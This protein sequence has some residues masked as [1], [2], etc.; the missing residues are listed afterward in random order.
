MIGCAGI[1]VAA[2]KSLVVPLPKL[3]LQFLRD[4]YWLPTILAASAISAAV[5]LVVLNE[6]RWLA[7][8]GCIFATASWFSLIAQEVLAFAGVPP[9]LPIAPNALQTIQIA[10]TSGFICALALRLRGYR[11]GRL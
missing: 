5:M 4:A 8:L 9:M 10:S 2:S 11:I 6:R 3:S 7:Q 1:V